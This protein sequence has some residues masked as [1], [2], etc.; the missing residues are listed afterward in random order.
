MRYY[1]EGWENLFA[2]PILALSLFCLG[3]EKVECGRKLF[4]CI[5]MKID[6][7]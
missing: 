5:K 3:F 6:R 1:F 7:S 2:S 4:L